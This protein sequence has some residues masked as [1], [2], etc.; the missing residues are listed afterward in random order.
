MRYT[1]DAASE[2][3]PAFADRGEAGQRL[4]DELS[5]MNYPNPAVVTIP[6]GGIPVALP[7]RDRLGVPLRC[8]FAKKVPF[9]DDCRFGIGA[10][11]GSGNVLLNTQLIKNISLQE[12]YVREGIAHARSIVQSNMENLMH[13]AVSPPDLSGRTAIL[14][15]DGIATGFTMLSAAKEVEALKPTSI[16]IASPVVSAS[17]HQRIHDL[18]YEQ[19]T[20]LLSTARAFLVDNF[21]RSF[22]QLS[23]DDVRNMLPTDRE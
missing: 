11:S 22:Q 3:E 21:Y 13:F 5:R 1:V 2:I 18:G 4:A 15:D 10:V 17:A 23:I 16:I 19:V 14:V 9:S 20:L 8:T 12:E 6:T 7:I